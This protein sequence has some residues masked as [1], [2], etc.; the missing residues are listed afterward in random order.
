MH[1]FSYD[2]HTRCI[3]P[4]RLSHCLPHAIRRPPVPPSPRS[5]RTHASF[6]PQFTLRYALL[7]TIPEGPLR[8]FVGP[9]I[10]TQMQ[11]FPPP[12]PPE[13]AH[14]CFV[15]PSF[16]YTYNKEAV[17][18]RG[19]A[20]ASFSACSALTRSL[21]NLKAPCKAPKVSERG[22]GAVLSVPRS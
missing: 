4:L 17:T 20:S 8:R 11:P 7:H 15:G 9:T 2:A 19:A 12:V 5:V 16:N 6:G 1:P 10:P 22:G 18:V 21:L 3:G 14:P 13:G